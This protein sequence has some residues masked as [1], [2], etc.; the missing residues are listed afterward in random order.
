MSLVLDE[1]NEVGAR[2]WAEVVRRDPRP[3]ASWRTMFTTAGPELIK[4]L[5]AGA[6]MAAV[7]ET[8]GFKSLAVQEWSAASQVLVGEIVNAL[9]KLPPGAPREQAAK[10]VEQ[11]YEKFKRDPEREQRSQDALR[12]L[13]Q[14]IRRR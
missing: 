7:A 13:V 3:Q 12:S 11:L 2:F 9:L 5:D 10:L 6:A 1:L 8:E 4:Q 14:P